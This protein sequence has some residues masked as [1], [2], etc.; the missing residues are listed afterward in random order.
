[1]AECDSYNPEDINYF[2]F[3]PF[4]LV[5]ARSGKILFIA[6]EEVSGHKNATG[7]HFTLNLGGK[8]GIV[9][10]HLTDPTAAQSHRT[11]FAIDQTHLDELLSQA[12]THMDGFLR[13]LVRRTVRR[14]RPG[15][16]GHHGMLIL[17]L[18]TAEADWEALGK[19]VRKKWKLDQQLMRERLV[20]GLGR[21]DL[22]A[23]KDGPFLLFRGRQSGS[24]IYGVVFKETDECGRVHLFW[25]KSSRMITEL[26]SA[27]RQIEPTV[28]GHLMDPKA[29]R[30]ALGRERSQGDLAPAE[31]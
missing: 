10:A 24:E 16:L 17:P 15:W 4:A 12:A 31:G 6:K 9:D 8:S 27:W 2:D 14:V 26:E 29:L 7:A 25:F 19:R 23:A 20:R 3:G 30:E 11:L 13:A 1:V 5:L 18:W 28:R 22:L 21:D